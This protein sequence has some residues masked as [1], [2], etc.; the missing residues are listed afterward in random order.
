M[1]YPE[2][3]KRMVVL[4]YENGKSVA[5]ISKDSGIPRNS[6]YRWVRSHKTIEA[7]NQQKRAKRKHIETQF[8]RRSAKQSLG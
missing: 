3:L 2:S 1:A 4:Q 5:E 7:E 6:I 8:F